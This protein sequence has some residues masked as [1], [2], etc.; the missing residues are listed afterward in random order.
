M[1]KIILLHRGD[2]VNYEENTLLSLLSPL[3]LSFNGYSLGIEFDIQFNKDKQ[4]ICYH[5]EYIK[6]TNKKIQELTKDELKENSLFILE[7]ILKNIN[8]EKFIIN[9]EI[10]NYN[11]EEINK[12]IF[13][14]KLLY[15]LG[16]YKLNIIISSYDYSIINYL[17]K[18]KDNLKIDIKIGYISDSLIDK[19]TNKIDILIINKD[20]GIDYINKLSQ[21]NKIL[22]FTIFNDKC[23][24]EDCKLIKLIGDNKN[25][26]Y[27][28]DNVYKLISKLNIL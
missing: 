19:G 23:D 8:N 9:I 25:V 1:N 10:K 20:L 12:N 2:V 7:D 13:C 24:E 17:I 18:K 21:L 5:N 27:I 28:T 6:N 15:I 16:K 3:K 14:D 4:L 22:L 26:G 11:L